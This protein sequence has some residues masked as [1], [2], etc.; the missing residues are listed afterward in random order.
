MSAHHPPLQ[1]QPVVA[2]VVGLPL[3][4]AALLLRHA[5]ALGQTPLTQPRV[6]QL[7]PQL[8]HLQQ[9][10]LGEALRTFLVWDPTP[11]PSVQHGPPSP[12]AGL[13]DPLS[14]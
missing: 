8:L 7:V 14:D 1:L 3:G 4:P 10:E 2:Q 11:P 12:P 6:T 13:R 5:A 9:Q